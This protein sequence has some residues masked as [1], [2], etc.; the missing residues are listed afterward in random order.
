MSDSDS[1]VFGLTKKCSFCK[2]H[3]DIRQIKQ[4]DYCFKSLC[5][6][7]LNLPILKIEDQHYMQWLNLL[8]YNDLMLWQ[9]NNPEYEKSF[10]L[11]CES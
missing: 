9:N 7:C 4:C 6:Q 1:E 8:L 11:A 5:N 2:N 10:C 3:K